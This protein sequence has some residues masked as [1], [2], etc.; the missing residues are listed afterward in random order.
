MN[1]FKHAKLWRSYLDKLW[2]SFWKLK[3]MKNQALELHSPL[4]KSLKVCK[5]RTMEK[6]KTEDSSFSLLLHFW[7]TSRSPF[8]TYHIPFQSSGSQKSNA[9]NRAWF[10]VE[11]RKNSLRKPTAPGYAKI[12]HNTFKIRITHACCEFSSVFADSTLDIFLCILWCNF[13][14]YPCN[15]L[16]IF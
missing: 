15:Q 4:P 13:L 2:Q 6:R 14:S 8:F 10:G 12:S 7:S 11:M 1:Q 9:S 5:E 16:K 3:F